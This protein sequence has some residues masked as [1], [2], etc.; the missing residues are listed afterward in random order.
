MNR[1]LNWLGQAVLYACFAIA[2]GVLSRW[3]VYHPL[4]PET[5]QIKVSFLHHGQRVEECRPYTEEEKAKMA[6]NM[7]KSMKCG[8]ERSPVHI[9]VDIDGQQVLSHT[10]VPAG[11]SRDGASTMYRRLNVPAGEH[12]ITVRF[13]DR[14]S[15]PEPTQQLEKTVALKSAQVL[16]IDYDQSRGGVVL[17]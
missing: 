6:P 3:P 13:K 15:S 11:L 4:P 10:A 2:L 7:R 12:R 16:V 1:T 14:M 9:E 8:R 5:A 17:Q